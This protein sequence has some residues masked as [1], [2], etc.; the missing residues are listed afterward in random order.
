[1][2][3]QM[4]KKTVDLKQIWANALA[5]KP[6][7]D[8]RVFLSDPKFAY[9]YAKYIRRKR[10]DESDELVFH[11]DLKC[12]YLYCVFVEKNP[13]EHLNNFMIAK[14]LDNL[15]E[16]DRRWVDEYFKYVKSLGA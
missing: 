14:N 9:L 16:Q 11:K 12:C 15:D 3:E 10:W 8:E 1:M 4:A 6:I 2:E 7:K 5:G 13:P